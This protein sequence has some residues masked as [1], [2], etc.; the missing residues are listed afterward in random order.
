MY[1]F[2]SISII[3]KICLRISNYNYNI[4]IAIKSASYHSKKITEHR[5]KY[6]SE[7]EDIKIISTRPEISRTYHHLAEIYKFHKHIALVKGN[8]IIIGNIVDRIFH[9]IINHNLLLTT[10]ASSIIIIE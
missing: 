10:N 3:K 6:F 4:N 1:Y 2:F 5:K 7:D 8:Q 9:C